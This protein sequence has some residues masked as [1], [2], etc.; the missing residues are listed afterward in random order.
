MCK[1]LRNNVVVLVI[2]LCL[3]ILK[4]LVNP[5]TSYVTGEPELANSVMPVFIASIFF[6]YL[7]FWMRIF[8]PIMSKEFLKRDFNVINFYILIG[9]GCL[10]LARLA[11]ACIAISF[12]SNS[13]WEKYVEGYF[14][15][16]FYIGLL[17]FGYFVK[18]AV[19]GY[20]DIL[21]TRN[22]V[23]SL[24]LETFIALVYLTG[25]LGDILAPYANEIASDN[26]L[27][28][29]LLTLM[30][31]LIF[32]IIYLSLIMYPTASL[33]IGA[34][35]PS[36]GNLNRYT[37]CKNKKLEKII[38]HNVKTK[39]G[40][41]DARYKDRGSTHY[42]K[43]SFDCNY[44][45]SSFSKVYTDKNELT[46]FAAIIR[47]FVRD[48]SGEQRVEKLVEKLHE[49]NKEFSEDFEKNPDKYGY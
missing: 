28:G 20:N 13:L 6:I 35:C 18:L 3:G 45:E 36:C 11:L 27:F 22:K 42:Y 49:Q 2:S 5:E 4:Y 15:I 24:M 26:L 44:C 17:C 9:D 31:F 30:P 8:R 38:D 47:G 14:L 21:H 29:I 32:I 33:W 7:F 12:F 40:V 10:L 19:V 37:H 1:V 34:P 16:E 46:G 25:P 39:D 48:L 23:Y 43:Y 41:D